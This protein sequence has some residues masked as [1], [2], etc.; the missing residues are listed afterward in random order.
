[1]AHAFPCF[2][3]RVREATDPAA[4]PVGLC[5]LASPVHDASALAVLT[6]ALEPSATSASD[7]QITV[8]A[9]HRGALPTGLRC[10]LPLT[11]AD[12]AGTVEWNRFCRYL[13]YGMEGR[14]APKFAILSCSAALLPPSPP[15]PPASAGEAPLP[16]FFC[17]ADSLPCAHAAPGS[18]LVCS[19]CAAWRAAAA[20]SA[21]P[22]VAQPAAPA[23]P[24][25]LAPAWT[26]SSADV[27]A[28]SAVPR[29][30]D[31]YVSHG[32]TYASAA[33]VRSAIAD[34]TVGAMKE[35]L[36][37]RIVAGDIPFP[38]K[39]AC[40]SAAQT[41]EWFALLRRYAGTISLSV[42]GDAFPL[43]GYLPN[44]GT[45]ECTVAAPLT[46]R[47]ERAVAT[48]SAADASS[49]SAAAA[50]PQLRIA[51]PP[52]RRVAVPEAAVTDMCGAGRAVLPFEHAFNE[53]GAA[54]VDYFSEPARM[55]AVW[56]A[57]GAPPRELWRRRD[58]AQWAVD[59]AVR[60]YGEL[61]DF[62][63]RHGLYGRV[64]GCNLFK[65]HLASALYTVLGGTRILD[66]CAGWGDRLLGAMGTVAVSRYLAFDPNPALVPA[67]GGMIEAFG[68]AAGGSYA[69]IPLPF[70]E[71]VIPRPPPPPAAAASTA[72]HEATTADARGGASGAA[73]GGAGSGSGS[74][75]AGVAAAAT[76]SDEASAAGSTAS[77]GATTA[78]A[79]AGPATAAAGV[80][81]PDFDL[82]FTS[83]PYF[84]LEIYEDERRRGLAP[85]LPTAGSS[86][87]TG[88]EAGAASPAAAAAG[89]D[90]DGVSK[91]STVKFPS[92]H[93]WLEG[94]FFPM[95]AKAWAHL[96]PG[97][98]MAFYINDH[99]GKEDAEDGHG[100]TGAGGPAAKRARRDEG[101]EDGASSRS[102][103][104]DVRDKDVDIHMCLPM[105]RFAGSRLQDC[106]WVGTVGVAGETGNLRPLW[107]WR[108]GD[109]IRP[110]AAGQI[111]PLYAMLAGR[112]AGQKPR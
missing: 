64:A 52:P 13:A 38:Y 24:S 42:S 1:M 83:P 75:G 23:P 72:A 93:A 46:A 43:H 73:A 44:G 100:R 104:P 57:E 97:G 86:G 112:L 40:I 10:G 63:L 88:G 70:E 29:G 61:T 21:A 78:A 95:M 45:F 66:P 56:K 109:A 19:S 26:V 62:S 91:Q 84:D 94:W 9:F 110:N 103:A 54:L 71:G 79:A 16:L 55:G 76:R 101:G 89:A 102:S 106:V 107:V 108:K 28:V 60:K 14:S 37:A 58:V 105:L 39:R 20:A 80:V 34:G 7:R 15:P 36:V 87:S 18:A 59:K 99:A 3:L 82:I 67:H 22:P 2:N 48:A 32:T 96:R 98:H 69:V 74:V 6:R 111:A 47:W 65:C 17:V 4:R 5:R 85:P 51:L 50:A 30:A 35:Q 31:A 53:V 41:R 90:G 27:A 25:V 68:A 49:S 77:A 12:P 33:A 11:C 92:L 81:E 8:R